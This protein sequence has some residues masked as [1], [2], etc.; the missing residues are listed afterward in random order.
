ME[1][2]GEAALY[3]CD[4]AADNVKVFCYL[5]TWQLGLFSAGWSG[6]MRGRC[7][8]HWRGGAGRWHEVP[9]VACVTLGGGASPPWASVSLAVK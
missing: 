2:K 5:A 3:L 8:A 7:S 9:R 1:E 6:G 4:I